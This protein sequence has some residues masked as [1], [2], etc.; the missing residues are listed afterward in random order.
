MR[1]VIALG[2]NALLE[3]GEG[4]DAAIQRRHVRRAA[5]ALAHLATDHQLIVCHGNGPQ[6]GLL[7]QE[8]ENDPALSQPYPLDVLGAQTQGMIG[9]WLVQELHNAG[10][11]AVAV[12]SR[13]VVDADDSAFATPTK[14]IGPGYDERRA[15]AIADRRGWRIGRDGER[16]RRV[17]ASP[18]PRRIVEMDTLAALA[19]RGGVVVCGGGGGA[20]VVESRDGRLDG[21]EAVVDKDLTAALLALRLGAQRLLVLTDVPAVMRDYGTPV[22]SPVRTV[23][24]DTLAGLRFPAGSMAPKVDACVRFVRASGHPAAIGA[25]DD[26]PAVLAGTSG[27]TVVPA[28]GSTGST[29]RTARNGGGNG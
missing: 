14:F 8:S 15:R 19:E 21:V 23:D 17:V 28:A 7:A 1:I 26:A 4:P 11:P 29:H 25:L 3:R 2:G 9:Y 10:A 5:T 27:T 24:V 16:W 6:V 13:T 20:P 22:A 12:L 18:E